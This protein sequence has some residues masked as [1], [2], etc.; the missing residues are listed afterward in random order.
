[1]ADSHFGCFCAWASP[2]APVYV[3]CPSCSHPA[4]IPRGSIGQRQV[5][6]QCYCLYVVTDPESMTAQ[7]E[8]WFP[9]PN[10]LLAASANTR[11]DPIA[12]AIRS[13]VLNE[14]STPS[15]LAG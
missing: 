1:M 5:C 13:A 2:G 15:A 10:L 3:T 8:L 12:A 14:R 9:E 4:I 6:R 7:V 11:D